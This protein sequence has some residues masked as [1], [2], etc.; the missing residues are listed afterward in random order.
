[1]YID[2]R[3]NHFLHLKKQQSIYMKWVRLQCLRYHKSYS[4]YRIVLNQS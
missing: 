4:G 3:G 1:M 2:L